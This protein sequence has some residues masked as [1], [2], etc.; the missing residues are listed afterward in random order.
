MLLGVCFCVVCILEGNAIFKL[1]CP[2]SK[3]SFFLFLSPG[4]A[5]VPVK[6]SCCSYS[7]LAWSLQVRCSISVSQNVIVQQCRQSSFF[8]TCESWIGLKLLSVANRKRSL[9]WKEH[10]NL[11]LVIF[12]IYSTCTSR[13]I[14]VATTFLDGIVFTKFILIAS[15]D[16]ICITMNPSQILN[17][18][19]GENTF[20]SIS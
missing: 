20:P 13:K 4:F 3:Q 6:G 19:G 7:S 8:N 12:C 15:E 10:N 1:K 14:I 5:S 9:L 18:M 17:C 2:L 11:F 16:L